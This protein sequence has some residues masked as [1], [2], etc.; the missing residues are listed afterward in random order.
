MEAQLP[1]L[2]VIVPL[3]AA[4]LCLLLRHRLLVYPFALA[5]AWGT[6]AMALALLGLLPHPAQALQAG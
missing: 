4:P 5:V 1:A 3:I 2:Q 6:F